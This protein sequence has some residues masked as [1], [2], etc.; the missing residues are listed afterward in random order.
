MLAVGVKVGS[1]SERRR[2]AVQRGPAAIRRRGDSAKLAV[3]GGGEEHEEG[4][5]QSVHGGLSITGCGIRDVR[6]FVQRCE[7]K[8]ERASA[9]LPPRVKHH[10]WEGTK[11]DAPSDNDRSAPAGSDNGMS[12]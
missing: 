10:P 8:H 3:G 12:L 1:S 11:D 9:A 6:V 4:A 5:N 7:T 2:R